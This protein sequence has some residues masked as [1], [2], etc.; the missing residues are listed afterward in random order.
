M[1]A[2]GVRPTPTP[3]RNPSLY[4]VNTRTW[5]AALSEG[6]GR[7]ATLDDVPDADLDAWAAT[8]FDLVYF[9]G[10]WQTGEAGRAVSRANPQWRAEF[11]HVLPDLTE[12]DIC[13]SCFAITGYTVAEEARW[14]RGPRASA[15]APECARPEADLGLRPQPHRSRPPLGR[16]AP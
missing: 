1:S 11:Q 7:R 16:R 10:V 9:L 8:G 3:G 4:Q 13:G 2:A 6:L 12:N 5:L 15:Q 14:R